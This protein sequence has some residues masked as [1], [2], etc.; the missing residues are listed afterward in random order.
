MFG[1]RLGLVLLASIAWTIGPTSASAATIHTET[2]ASGTWSAR[3]TYATSG[4]P[5][6]RYADLR[7]TVTHRGSPVLDAPVV[8]RLPGGSPV[9]PGGLDGHSSVAFG[10]LNGA[11]P[12]AVLTLYTGGAHCCFIDQVYDFDFSTPRR[13]EIDLE[14]AGATLRTIDG[15]TVFV[16]A[17]ER[18]AYE[19]T[20]FAYSGE[21]LQLWR[22]EPGRFIDVTRQYPALVARDAASWWAAYEQGKKPTSPAGGDVRGSLAA[23]AADEAMLGHAD[24]AKRT[25]LQLAAGGTL[26]QGSNAGWPTGLAYVQALWRFLAKN[27]YLAAAGAATARSGSGAGE[28]A[29]FHPLSVTFVSSEQGWALGTGGCRGRVCLELFETTDAGRSWSPRPLPAALVATGPAIAKGGSTQLADG[30]FLDIRFADPRDGWIYGDTTGS[31]PTVWSTHDGGTVWRETRPRSLGPRGRIFDLEAAAGG[32]YL[33]GLNGAG[34][35]VVA[36]AA[37]SGDRWRILSTPPL[38]SPAGGGA[39]GGALV[40]QGSTGWIVE[41]ND[42]GTT[43]SARL[44]ASG[45]WVAWT[46]PCAAVGGS[47]AVPAA[48]NPSSLVAVCVMGGFAFP[49]S[50]AAPPGATLHSSWLYVSSDGG[51]TFVA[52]PEL[53]GGGGGALATPAP[54]VVLLGGAQGLSESLDGGRHWSTVYHGNLVYL[55]FTTPTQGVGITGSPGGATNT[56][57]LIMSY[58]GGRHWKQVAF[59]TVGAAPARAATSQPVTTRYRGRSGSK[60]AMS[61]ELTR[62]VVS[63]FTFENACPGAAGGT[64]VPAPMRVVAGRFSFRDRQF[65]VT[66]R[67]LTGGAARGTAED[68]TGN[69]DSGTLTWTAAASGATV[70]P[71]AQDRAQI[72]AS[73]GDPPAAARCL[74][75]GLAASD[76]SYATVVYDSGS[77]SCV[78]YGFNGL[79]ILRDT[80]GSWR[81]VF[82]ASAYACPVAHVPRS[83]Q[84]DLGVCPHPVGY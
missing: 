55:G 54:G 4:S 39:Q 45:R 31:S 19:F 36:R 37:A 58:D 48:A 18:F 13:T 52:G 34:R 6:D 78:R 16:S 10:D 41:G 12:E 71:T 66:G 33:L 11:E 20:A 82:E 26:S 57:R 3:F 17:N 21:P 83:V 25:L 32:A 69:C 59:P 62:G 75:I 30:E 56:T 73:F 14:D 68:V 15:R 5:V 51:E 49:L 22:Y 40:L 29:V 50:K 46:P 38:G 61:F 8:S 81:A 79:N 60:D 70:E 65:A 2:A 23:W 74:T 77:A 76:H 1:S 42:R 24:T 64:S 84:R 80:G 43:G 27:G 44:D 9:G 35:V 63:G 67:L 72:L 7:L 28:A 47:F 53:H